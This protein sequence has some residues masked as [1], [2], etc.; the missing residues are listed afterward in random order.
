[1][2]RTIGAVRN[3]DEVVDAKGVA[4]SVAMELIAGGA[5][6]FTACSVRAGA[7]FENCV[8]AVFVAFD[9]QAIKRSVAFRAVGGSE[10]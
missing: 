4:A 9:G 2:Q 1:M 3:G 8:A 5:E 10:T 7:D 6:K